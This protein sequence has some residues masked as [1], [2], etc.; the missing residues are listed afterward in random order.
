M[1]CEYLAQADEM[2]IT[3]CLVSACIIWLTPPFTPRE[4]IGYLL[5]FYR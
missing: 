3:Y 4:D 5:P 1:D 2:E